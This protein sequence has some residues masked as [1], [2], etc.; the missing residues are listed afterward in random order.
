MGM[1]SIHRN[2]WESPERVEPD[3]D[4]PWR[5]PAAL[6]PTHAHCR[7]CAYWCGLCGLDTA[8]V[9]LPSDRCVSW[10][11]HRDFSAYMARMPAKVDDEK[12]MRTG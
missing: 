4:A 12:N 1:I 6:L 9:K 10:Q 2:T 8:R 11:E 3:W 7:N 5:Q